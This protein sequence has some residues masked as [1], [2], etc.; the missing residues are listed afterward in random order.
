MTRA[1]FVKKAR[2]NNPVANKGESYWWWKFKRGGKLYSKDRPK[3]SQLIRSV[4][5][6]TYYSILESMDGIETLVDLKDNF[7]SWKSEI[8]EMKYETEEK[9]ENMP[10][11]LKEGDIGQL[12]QERIQGLEDWI[13]SLDSIE[14]PDDHEQEEGDE[15]ETE[16]EFVDRLLQEIRDTDPGLS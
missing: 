7:D 11:P 4:F 2:K 9:Y 8:E 13:N 15:K 12:L 1:H 16:E 14:I 6:S 3:A 10:D 5:L